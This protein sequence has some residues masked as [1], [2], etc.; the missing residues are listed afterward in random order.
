MRCATGGSALVRDAL[1]VRAGTVGVQVEHGAHVLVEQSEVTMTHMYSVLHCK[2][3][4][5]CI[6]CSWQVRDGEENGIVICDGAT[7]VIQLTE[8]AAVKS[9]L[10]LTTTHYTG[11]QSRAFQYRNRLERLGCAEAELNTRHSA[12][13]QIV[14]CSC[15]R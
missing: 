9:H 4:A 14:L 8:V 7:A 11:G 1:V 2:T 15:V 12:G 5:E 3:S 6:D 13:R 10:Q